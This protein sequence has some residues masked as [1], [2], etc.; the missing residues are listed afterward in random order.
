[1]ESKR[2]GVSLE[3]D[4]CVVPDRVSLLVGSKILYESVHRVIY[5][6]YISSNFLD[7]LLNLI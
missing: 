5:Y 4:E 2:I 3:L 6:V 1:M 7:I